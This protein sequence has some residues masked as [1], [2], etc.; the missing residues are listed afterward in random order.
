[1]LT[2]NKMDLE[3]SASNIDSWKKQ[4]PITKVID[5][6]SL[7]RLPEIIKRDLNG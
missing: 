3:N 2:D 5:C 6:S 4:S 1:M 7:M